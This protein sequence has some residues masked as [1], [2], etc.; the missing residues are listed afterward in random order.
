MR[1]LDELRGVGQVYRFTLAQ[2]VK[3][4][5]NII[6]VMIMLVISM[7]MV[8]VASLMMGGANLPGED[9]GL[10]PSEDP[11]LP[12]DGEW[13]ITVVC[14]NNTS[15]QA[16]LKVQ[17]TGQPNVHIRGYEQQM[18]LLLS[19]ADLYLTKPGGLSTTEALA[20]AVPMVFVDAVARC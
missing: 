20:A 19:S 8:P 12:D 17:Y 10:S 13:E 16:E 15:L 14:G 5:A 1:K 3:N 4:R 9:I 18:P 2:H 11:H 7:A 6:S